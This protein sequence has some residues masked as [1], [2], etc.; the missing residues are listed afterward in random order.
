MTY[1]KFDLQFMFNNI[2][3]EN[4]NHV[5]TK[6]IVNKQITRSENKQQCLYKSSPNLRFDTVIVQNGF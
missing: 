5:L 3:F 4:A 2:Y 1:S 6:K